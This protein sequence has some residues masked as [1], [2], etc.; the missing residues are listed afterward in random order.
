MKPTYQQIEEIHAACR[1]LGGTYNRIVQRGSHETVEAV[2]YRYGAKGKEVRLAAAHNMRVLRPLLEE[3]NDLVNA[4]LLEESDNTGVIPDSNPQAISRY[5]QRLLEL[6]RQPIP[7][8]VALVPI[9][10]DD[11][12]LDHNPLPPDVLVALSY[13][14][15][16]AP[17]APA[18]DS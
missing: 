10:E 7:A 1:V 9:T 2:P 12:A 16:A 6:R 5:N 11:L 14:N 18:G 4:L 15:T 13:I 3:F 8:D 17:A